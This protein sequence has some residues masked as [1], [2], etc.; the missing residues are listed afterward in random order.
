MRLPASLRA[1][2]YGIGGLVAASGLVWLVAHGAY[3]G[4]ATL[5]MEIHGTAAM[6][7]LVL[8]GVAAGMHAPAAWRERKNRS[9]GVLFGVGLAALML[10]G[11]LL[12]YA[13][14]E[15]VRA[16]ASIAHW[17]VGLVAI[18]LAVLHIALG[19]KTSA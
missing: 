17:A 3:N 18:A 12:Y 16:S 4:V 5:C 15:Q 7:L 10:T 9:S 1:G 2:L 19:R 14:S 13:G 6:I 8:I 11:A